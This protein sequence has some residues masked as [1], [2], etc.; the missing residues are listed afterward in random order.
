ML[1]RYIAVFGAAQSAYATHTQTRWLSP[2]LDK[3]A[4]R[5]GSSALGYVR[6][7][8]QSTSTHLRQQTKFF[9]L[10]QIFRALVN[11]DGEIHCILPNS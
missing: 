6:T 2:K 11:V 8:R 3:L 10:R 4:G 1:L 5:I 7:N 9:G